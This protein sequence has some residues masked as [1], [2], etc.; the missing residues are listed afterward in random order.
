MLGYVYG[1]SKSLWRYPTLIV[2]LGWADQKL[3]TNQDLGVKVATPVGNVFGQVIFGWLADRV[4][5]KRMCESLRS[6]SAALN[7][8]MMSSRWDRAHNHDH[9]YIWASHFWKWRRHQ[10]H[11]RPRLLAVYG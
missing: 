10:H 1:H 9:C 3:G 11:W 2:N 5:R 6:L 7:F 4:G 8:L